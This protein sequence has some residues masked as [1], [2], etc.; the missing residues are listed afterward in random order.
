M[1]EIVN[2]VSG[3]TITS[4]WGNSIRDRTIQRYAS[5][6]ARTAAH[7]SPATGDMSF[8][9]DTGK[10]YVY[11]SGAWRLVT[12][13]AH[14]SSHAAGGSDPLGDHGTAHDPGGSDE[15]SLEADAASS[16]ASFTTL[17][18]FSDVCTATLTIPA[19]WGGWKC[20]A[21]ASYTCDGGTG[22]N[23]LQTV[24]RI[25]GTDGP[26]NNVIVAGADRASGSLIGRRTGIT[27]T[28]SAT[29]DF[30]AKHDAGTAFTIRTVFL[31][32]RAIRTS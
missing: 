17:T 8:L 30:R 13:T 29:V 2:V 16:T 3:N 15:L 7:A 27:A 5:A 4:V 14:G 21:A 12:D 31:Y 19:T 24:M 28:G 1:P 25:N 6:A 20:F 22:S 18:G 10:V 32:A 9:T 11:S 26:Q 23:Q